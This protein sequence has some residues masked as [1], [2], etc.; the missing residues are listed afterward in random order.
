MSNF[1]PAPV[2]FVVETMLRHGHA[3]AEPLRA[4][5]VFYLLSFA[6]LDFYPGRPALEAAFS[7]AG[8][9]ADRR[10]E[11]F[12]LAHAGYLG[13]DEYAYAAARAAESTGEHHHG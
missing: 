4:A 11:A 13:E 7:P 8:T 3:A 12:A 9:L 1:T 5:F 6:D 10:R 2:R